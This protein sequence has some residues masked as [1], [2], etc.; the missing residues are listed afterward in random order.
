MSGDERALRLLPAHFRDA[1]ER[2]ASVQRARERAIRPSVLDVM[3]AQNAALAPSKAREANLDALATPGTVCVVTGQQVGL[4]LGPLYTIYKAASA[5][6][7][8]NA[9]TRETGQ[10][11][12]PVF[13][14]QTEDHDL[15]E[16]DHV[17]VP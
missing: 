14:L 6:A 10:R 16:I 17:V 15:A 2:A 13:W 4:F 1:R 3:R 7:F 12:V 8:A 5:I 11:C 9:L